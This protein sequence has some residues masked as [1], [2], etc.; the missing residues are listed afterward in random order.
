[1][2]ELIGLRANP[3]GKEQDVLELVFLASEPKY[4]VSNDGTL[5]RN[6]TVY[7]FRILIKRDDLKSLGEQ[8]IE[9]A[10][11]QFEKTED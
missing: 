3:I 5:I 6:R 8:L 10:E 2:K 11:K 7:D 9:A 1:M 4:D